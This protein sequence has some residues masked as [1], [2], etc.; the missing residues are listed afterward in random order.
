ME[1]NVD[2]SNSDKISDGLVSNVEQN[3]EPGKN[4]S[5]CDKISDGLV[6]NMEQKCGTRKGSI[7][8]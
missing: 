1:Q 8:L 2:P 5:N 7:K 4:P 3:M 6:S